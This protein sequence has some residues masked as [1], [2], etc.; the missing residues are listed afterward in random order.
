MVTKSMPIK[1]GDIVHLE[2]H[3]LNHSGE[4]VGRYEGIAVFVPFVVPGE[5]VMVK[6][7]QTRKNFARGELLEIVEQARLRQQPGCECFTRCGGCQLQHVDYP[8]QLSLKRAQVEAAL[9]RIGGLQ[10]VQVLPTLGMEVPWAYRNKVNF[11]VYSEGGRLR[12]GYTQ[13]DIEEG[14]NSQ[15]I[16][17]LGGTGC[18]LISGEMREAARL[19]EQLLNETSGDFRHVVL[20]QSRS[21]EEIMIVVVTGGKPWQGE[22]AW[23]AEL[24]A[25]NK[26]ITSVIRNISPDLKGV[27]LGPDSRVL[28]GKAT[29]TDEIHGVKFKISP[30][31]FFQVNPEM[32]AQ[33]YQQVAL[34]AGL[35]GSETVIDAYCGAGTIALYLADSA[36]KVVGLEIVPQAVRDAKANAILNGRGNVEFRVGK[37]EMLLPELAQ[38]GLKPDLVVLDPPRKGCDRAALE[39]IGNLGPA[40]IVYV[41]CD[42][43]SLA[44]DLGVLEGLG[45]LVRQVQP[46]DMFG[47]TAH[48]ECV[49]LIERV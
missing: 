48:V 5:R 32:T 41:S 3:G 24:L 39:A 40:R 25:R 26:G 6:I 36:A 9:K 11:R 45:Y 16:G 15:P 23:A 8:E 44:R 47:Q 12:L 21:T 18:L 22:K 19:T 43:A 1:Q 29:L 46:V 13:N 28:A 33:L 7:V 4:G 20:R 38:E 34:F 27:I 17:L 42:P 30:Q 49:V 37:C 31:S 10:D 35:T 14:S 2:I